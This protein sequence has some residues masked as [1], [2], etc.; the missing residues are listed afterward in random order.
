M[1]C[2]SRREEGKRMGKR[3]TKGEIRRG[4]EKGR[5]G[6]ETGGKKKKKK[7]MRRTGRKRRRWGR[8]GRKGERARQTANK[9]TKDQTRS[10]TSSSISRLS[11]PI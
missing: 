11:M 1:E 2:M 9:G 8:E 6:E 3:K 4:T 7:K 5:K 10:I